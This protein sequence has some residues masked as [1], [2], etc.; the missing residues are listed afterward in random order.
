MISIALLTAPLPSSGG[1]LAS[2]LARPEQEYSAP[3]VDWVVMSMGHLVDMMLAA[4]T[5]S[6]I[7]RLVLNDVGP[8]IPW[9]ALQ[10]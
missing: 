3:Q 1:F 2:L 6:P 9:R 8:L 10:R 4:Y 7:R 5:G